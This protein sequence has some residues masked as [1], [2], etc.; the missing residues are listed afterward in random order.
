MASL[1][2]ACCVALCEDRFAK[3]KN[4]KLIYH[5]A[6]QLKTPHRHTLEFCRILSCSAN[7][8]TF[9]RWR[10]TYQPWELIGTRQWIWVSSSLMRFRD[11]SEILRKTS[12]VTWKWGSRS[13]LR[14]D[15]D[16]ACWSIFPKRISRLTK[17]LYFVF[18][19]FRVVLKV[20]RLFGNQIRHCPM[21]RDWYHAP[22]CSNV[23]LLDA[24]LI[25]PL[26]EQSCCTYM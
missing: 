26:V 9:Q 1:H 13:K 25:H 17:L 23:G 16:S 14:P 10:A 18:F 15:L 21:L 2:M 8:T 11:V 4:V 3:V 20:L 5:V 22:R 24:I 7:L 6:L 12:K 19:L